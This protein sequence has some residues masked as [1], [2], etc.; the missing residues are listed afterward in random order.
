MFYIFVSP[1]KKTCAGELGLMSKTVNS[2]QCSTLCTNMSQQCR[3][4]VHIFKV[5]SVPFQLF[6][7]CLRLCLEQE[8]NKD[9]V[10]PAP[11]AALEAHEQGCRELA[12]GFYRTLFFLRQRKTTVATQR[13]A[14]CYGALLGGHRKGNETNSPLCGVSF[15]Q[16]YD[17]L[18]HQ[19]MSPGSRG[20]GAVLELPLAGDLGPLPHPSV[21]SGLFGE[22]VMAIPLL[23][24]VCCGNYMS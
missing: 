19:K 24:K 10:V 15:C 23:S 2:S 14:W 12:A 11:E 6:L 13:G 20:G 8:T 7:R 16:F 5:C 4:S 3:F 22:T 21:P 18:Y 9:S 17:S 1:P